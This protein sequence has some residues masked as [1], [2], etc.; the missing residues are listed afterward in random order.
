LAE[1][2][3]PRVGA[4]DLGP[5]QWRG[6]QPTIAKPITRLA[7]IAARPLTQINDRKPASG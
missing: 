1:Q 2:A 7:I 4:I 3:R 6:Q 5:A